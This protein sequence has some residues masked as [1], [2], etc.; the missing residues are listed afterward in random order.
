MLACSPGKGPQISQGE[1][2]GTLTPQGPD[3]KS[4]PD[5][6]GNT[7]GHGSA[8]HAHAGQTEEAV[9]QNGV[10]HDVQK[11]HHHGDAHHLAQQGIAPQHSAELDV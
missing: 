7:G 5:C 6:L 3:H 10:S 11:I 4:Q 8:R 1:A 9:D 2:D